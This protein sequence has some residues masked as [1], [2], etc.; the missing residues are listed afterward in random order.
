[1]VVAAAPAHPAPAVGPTVIGEERGE[2]IE[3]KGEAEGGDRSAESGEGRAERGEGIET[4]EEGKAES[5]E[6]I[7]RGDIGAGTR[8]LMVGLG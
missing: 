2:I 1:M 6:P 4:S 5:G 3:G 7:V 8:E